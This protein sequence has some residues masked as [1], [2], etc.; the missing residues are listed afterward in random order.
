MNFVSH[1]KTG[2]SFQLVSA[3]FVSKFRRLKTVTSL[4]MLENEMYCSYGS[5]N[6]L[7]L[8]LPT[9][10]RAKVHAVRAAQLSPNIG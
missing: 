7:T 3:I 2:K 6:Y 10:T 5:Q 4:T 1:W 8:Y 9:K